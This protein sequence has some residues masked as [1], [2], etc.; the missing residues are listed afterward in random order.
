MCIVTRALGVPDPRMFNVGCHFQY[1]GPN[2]Y[3]EPPPPI[4]AYTNA[5]PCAVSALFGRID[6]SMAQV[7]HDFDNIHVSISV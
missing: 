5:V 6:G 3:P 2:S 4:P 1:L 7:D